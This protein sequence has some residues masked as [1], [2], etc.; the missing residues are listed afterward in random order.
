MRLRHVSL[1]ADGVNWTMKQKVIF[2]KATKM[3]FVS[4][5]INDE[6]KEMWIMIIWISL[7]TDLINIDGIVLASMDLLEK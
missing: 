1:D 6:N 3:N 7:S 4:F 5:Y 2:V